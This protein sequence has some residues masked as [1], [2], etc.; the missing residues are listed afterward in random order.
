MNTNQNTPDTGR[1]AATNGLAVVGFIALV[2]GGMW[3]AVYSA[4][5]VP[6]AVSKLG[7]AAVSLTQI[8]NPAPASISVIPTATTTISFGGETA[9]STPATTTPPVVTPTPKPTP[10]PTPAPGPSTTTTAPISGTPGTPAALYGFP[11][12]VTS[13]TVV[14]YLT[15]TSGDS[16][17]GGT[18][19]PSGA[20]PAVK[21][22]VR[23]AGTNATGPWRFTAVIPTKS[24]YTYTSDLQQNLNPGESIDYTLGFDEADRGSNKTITIN[25][26]ADHAIADTNFNNNSASASVTIE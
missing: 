14:G 8:F 22:T 18:T 21:F 7:A 26:D 6:A 1:A 4:R 24:A 13:I 23:N 15:G 3:L 20:R 10:A 2:L 19:V 9:T 17:V 16:F 11:D 12:F 25:A 5:F